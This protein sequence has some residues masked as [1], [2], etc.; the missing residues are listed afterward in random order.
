MT[1]ELNFAE[2]FPP[3]AAS[4]VGEGEAS[5]LF[6]LVLFSLRGMVSA[7]IFGFL[8][9][10][11]VMFCVTYRHLIPYT[12]GVACLACHQYD[13]ATGNLVCSHNPLTEEG[14]KMCVD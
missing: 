13:L 8:I 14:K 4:G 6:A 12:S 9:G 5:P 10:V 11:V 7:M 1:Y 3:G 2:F